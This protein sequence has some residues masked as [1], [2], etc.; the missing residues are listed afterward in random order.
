[1]KR[2]FRASSVGALLLAA[3][4]GVTATPVAAS[5][6]ASAASVP[7]R[8]ELSI[9]TAAGAFVPAVTTQTPTVTGSGSSWTWAAGTN[10]VQLSPATGETFKVGTF[11]IG[12]AAGQL[13]VQV[14][15]NSKTCTTTGTSR[16]TVHDVTYDGDNVTS[17]AATAQ[18]ACGGTGQ[19]AVELRL[20]STVGAERGWSQPLGK[21]AGVR[22]I[23]FTSP[24]ASTVKDV[25]WVGDLPAEIKNNTCANEALPAGGTCT[26]DVYAHPI[27]DGA[28][29]LALTIR[30]ADGKRLDTTSIITQNTRQPDGSYT[31][32]ATPRRFADTRQ[33]TPLRAGAPRDFQITGVNGMPSTGVSAV[34][35]N[36]TVVSPSANSYVTAYPAGQA[37]PTASSINYTKGWTG[38]NAVTVKVG[39]GSLYGKIRLLAGSGSTHVLVDVVGYYRNP[40]GT[41]SAAGAYGSYHAFEPFRLYDS[42]KDVKV[43]GYEIFD[44]SADFG[45]VN[46]KIKALAMNV[47]AVAPEGS[48]YLT[49]WNGIGSID[50]P[51]VS[52]LNFTTGRTV[53]NMTVVPV[54]RQGT[55][56]AFTVANGSSKKVHVIVDIIGVFDDDTLTDGSRLKA[57]ATPKRILD[58]RYG[59]GFGRLGPGATG[60]GSAGSVAG[61]WTT[62]LS[63]NLTAVA[64]SKP[65]WLTIWAAGDPKP[66]V[67]AMNPYAGKNVASMVMPGLSESNQYSINNADGTTHVLLDVVGTFEYYRTADYAPTSGVLTGNGPAW[68]STADDGPS[69][70]TPRAGAAKGTDSADSTDSEAGAARIA[71][72]RTLDARLNVR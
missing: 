28:Q 34:V 41:S 31:P 25:A 26:V 40:A 35:V 64:P 8:N 38:A 4:V 9:V 67:S 45:S 32:L 37:V 57:Q 58:S 2:W 43:N 54:G 65:T 52:T 30:D 12:T 39:T 68:S 46:P 56:P 17:L 24:E 29:Y 66:G 59:I 16:V 14:T 11:A 55:V 62:S 51:V 18:V 21:D 47:T 19:T 20:N 22:R 49:L 27:E 60:T 36:L 15:G 53:P 61:A 23:T 71:P 42:R 44:L 5:T 70:A 3:G 48:G 13:G 50:V 10:S 72:A 63:A 7:V 33:T 6:A 69:A 1:M